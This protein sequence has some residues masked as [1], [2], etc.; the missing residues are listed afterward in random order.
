MITRIYPEK[1]KK[2]DESRVISPSSSLL[3]TGTFEAKLKAKERLEVL[4]FKVAIT[5]EAF[6][7]KGVR[8]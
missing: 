2:G 6:K 8:G 7:I 4:G 1:L 5:T 3:R